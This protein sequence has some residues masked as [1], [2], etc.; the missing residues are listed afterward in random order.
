LH[1]DAYATF[2]LYFI[3]CFNVPHFNAFNVNFVIN[4]TYL[5]SYA[6]VIS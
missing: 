2:G 4:N 5:A 1:Y 3:Y 6:A